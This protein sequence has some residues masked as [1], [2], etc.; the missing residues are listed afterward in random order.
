MFCFLLFA[1]C[2]TDDVARPSPPKEFLRLN[3]LERV[4]VEVD[5]GPTNARGLQIVTVRLK[6]KDNRPQAVHDLKL[7]LST[8]D[9]MTKIHVIYP[10]GWGTNLG[11]HACWAHE[12]ETAI[13]AIIQRAPGDRSPVQGRLNFR[14]SPPGY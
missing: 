6:M 7:D 11:E 4:Q 2:G 13:Q 5:A 8:R 9:P 14:A 1:L 12:G 10:K 3:S